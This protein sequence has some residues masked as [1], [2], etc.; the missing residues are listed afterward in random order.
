[1][2]NIDNAFGLRP[3][4]DH[5][6][7]ITG[8]VHTYYIGA[9]YSTA[10]GIGDPVRSV[11]ASDSL[12]KADANGVAAVVRAAAGET[13]RGVIVGFEPDR[14]NLSN[15]Y[16]LA[17]TERYVRVCDDPNTIFEVQCNASLTTDQIGLNAD[18]AA[19]SLSTATG[20]SGY[21]LDTDG[22]PAP[23][24]AT[25]QCRIM[26]IRPS[27]DNSLGTNVIAEVLINEHE[28]KSTTGA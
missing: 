15:V 16:R 11:T 9:D 28:L 10:L 17:S 6:G 20:L 5:H 19:G 2:A 18:L 23:A 13:I 25:A 1:M 24:T 26:G 21:E 4:R 7:N 27:L 3:K 8:E 14:D 12:T 22:S